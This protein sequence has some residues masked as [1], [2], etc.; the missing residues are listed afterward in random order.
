MNN[1]PTSHGAW[2]RT[3]PAAPPTAPLDRDITVDVAIVG[4]GYTGLSAALHLARGG[5]SV[6][7]AEAVEV[8]FGGSGRNV[9]LVN[10]GM[11]VM[12]DKITETL[13]VEMGE[14][15]LDLLGQGPAEV[16]DLIRAESINCE[17]QTSGTLH[18]AV[19]ATC[20]REIT[21]RSE[22]WARRGVDLQVLNGPDAASALGTDAYCGALL[23]HRAGTIQPLAYARGLAQAAQNAGAHIFT[24]TPVTDI[25]PGPN[26]V[27]LRT[28]H[29]RITA[30][31]VILATDAYTQHI[32]PEI[33]QTQIMLPYFNFATKPLSDNL[34][35]TILPSRQGAWDTREVLSSFRMDAA[36][37][38]IF[39]SIG[40]FRGTGQSVH[41]GWAQRAI[42]R[43]FPQLGAVAFES[44]WYG[45]IGMTA[46]NMPRLSRFG[47]D[48]LAIS[49]YNGR[50][51]AP[52]TVFGRLL[53]EHLN[54][55]RRLDE[56]P[57]PLRDLSVPPMARLREPF[58]ALG[59]Q[60][61]HLVENRF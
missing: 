15:L 19:R 59:A 14:R 45:Q 35:Q 49:G 12:P 43:I 2:E 7:V 38:L 41:R 39:G 56:I 28:P 50:G 61:V 3:A 11:W 10:A 23:D 36:G 53:A 60:L 8:G 6:A 58:I 13:G 34:R 54:G 4:A 16:F 55:Q 24:G 33:R 44:G 29:G 5:Q 18:C 42:A 48:I 40:S 22:Q 51:I 57:L 1:D 30:G 21:Q 25:H 20:Q 47:P 26:G 27:T 17:A 32:F 52:G 31:K 37:R 9:G 46:D